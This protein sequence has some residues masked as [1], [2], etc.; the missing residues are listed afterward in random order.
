MDGRTGIPPKPRRSTMTKK[1]TT[2]TTTTITAVEDAIAADFIG[3]RDEIRALS[4]GLVTGTNV[5]L[6]GPGGVAKSAICR[7][8]ARR[9][10]APHWFHQFNRETTTR[11]VFGHRDMA[12]LLAGRV[13]Y[14]RTGTIVE[15]VIAIED[16]LFNAPSN[17]L[18][19]LN[20][21][22]NE[23]EYHEPGAPSAVKMPLRT[24]WA[25]ANLFPQISRPEVAAAYDRFLLRSDDRR[26]VLA[27]AKRLRAGV[28]TS[29]TLPYTEVERLAAAC[30]GVRV[31]DL[32]TTVLFEAV[33]KLRAE[34]VSVSPRREALLLHAATGHAVVRSNGTASE[35]ALADM[36]YALQHG[37]WSV[38][39]DRPKV[40][41]VLKKIG[42]PAD[43]YA[44]QAVVEVTALQ[45]K[46]R[47][48]VG[49][50]NLTPPEKVNEIDDLAQSAIR[51]RD[52]FS[53]QTEKP[54]DIEAY[55]AAIR[56]VGGFGAFVRDQITQMMR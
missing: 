23:R 55:E 21:A 36:K 8:Y 46:V 52:G 33:D 20:L 29:T 19:A 28:E 51:I 35:V 10:E 30:E 9:V 15:A 42:T 38:L 5:F 53:R 14:I 44:A 41:E 40:A 50:D 48:V 25:V 2:T 18:T 26:Q 1:T 3:V 34:G 4:V 49:N 6:H 32:I 45:D 7:A 17:L 47:T 37:C 56:F 54:L 31:S 12:A 43:Q 39:E 13:E 27:T 16:E 22:H 24:V 11:D